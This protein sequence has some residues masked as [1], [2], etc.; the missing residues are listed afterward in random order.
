MSMS[1][2]TEGVAVTPVAVVTAFSTLFTK[3]GGDFSCAFAGPTST[4]GE[5]SPFGVGGLGLFWLTIV[6][7]LLGDVDESERQ[8]E[9]WRRP[10]NQFFCH[11]Q[12]PW[13]MGYLSAKE[14]V[15]SH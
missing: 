13:A 9:G 3:P 1:V 10:R 11:P 2:D 4:G 8:K 12:S 5:R 15:I 6:L 7:N 14:M